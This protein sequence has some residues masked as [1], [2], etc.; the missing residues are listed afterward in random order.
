LS[1]PEKVAHSPSAV[2]RLQS[3]F[4]ITIS[5]IGAYTSGALLCPWGRCVEADDK[6]SLRPPRSGLRRR[7]R[8][9]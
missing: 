5:M 3:P 9:V 2:S 7:A 1:S 4:V 6:A 8:V